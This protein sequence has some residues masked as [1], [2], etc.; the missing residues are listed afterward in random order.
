M[1]TPLHQSSEQPCH[2]HARSGRL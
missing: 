2:D 1:M